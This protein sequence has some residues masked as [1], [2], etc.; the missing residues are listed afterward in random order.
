MSMTEYGRLER[1]T[2]ARES[3]CFVY[4]QGSTFF[5]SLILLPRWNENEKDNYG[6]KVVSIPRQE[7]QSHCRIV[8]NLE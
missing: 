5:P 6:K 7:E 3:A 1:S 4:F 8:Y 2:T